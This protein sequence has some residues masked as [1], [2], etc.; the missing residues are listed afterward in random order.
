MDNEFENQTDAN[1]VE[2]TS[3]PQ[4][5]SQEPQTEVAA[6]AETSQDEKPFHEHPRF[7][8]LID[9]RNKFREEMEAQKRQYAELERQMRSFSTQAQPQAKPKNMALEELREIKPELASYIENTGTAAEKVAALEAQLTEMRRQTIINQYESAVNSLYTANNISES[10]KPIYN[11]L[12]KNAVMEANSPLSDVPAVFS[13]IHG[14]MSQLIDGIKKETT[15]SYAEGKKQDA[16]SPKPQAKGVPVKPG[17]VEYSN[18]PV[19]RRSQMIK[20][21][22]KQSKASS[23]I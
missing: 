16:S 6:K 2:G 17:K 4:D 8:E 12:I 10:L 18:D 15:K 21:I 3:E 7:K 1:Q 14:Q 19:E 5:N 11:T 13:K 22:L 20:A 23:S 9:E